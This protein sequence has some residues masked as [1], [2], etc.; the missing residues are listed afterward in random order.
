MEATD[1]FQVIGESETGEA[2]VE[3]ARELHPDLVLMDV[4]L[5]GINGLEAT[6]RILGSCLTDYRQAV[7]QLSGGR[8]RAAGI[9]RASGADVF[10]ELVEHM[11]E[12]ALWKTTPI[13]HMTWR[14]TALAL[15]MGGNVRVGLED[16]FYLPDGRMVTSNG[17]LVAQ[18]VKMA[19]D[20]G[21]EPATVGEA[22]QAL[23]LKS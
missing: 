22:K 15:G 9:P 23:G 3:A 6:R 10:S 19:R 21:R 12:G 11:P 16:N 1:G 14:L 2:S 4:N 7:A 8:S 13:S 17:E 18:A 5:P 20:V